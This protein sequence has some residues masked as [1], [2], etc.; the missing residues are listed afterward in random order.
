MI[1]ALALVTLL[2]IQKEAPQTSLMKRVVDFLSSDEMAGRNTPS[3]ELDQ[4]ADYIAK[5]F[6]EQNLKP[7]NG[8]SYFQ[9]TNWRTTETKVRNVIAILPGNDPVLKNEYVYLTAHYDHLG[10]RKVEDGKDGIYNGA[11]DNASGTA[12]VLGAAMTLAQEKPKRTIVFMTF[13][14]EEKGLVG[15]QFY[16]K[17]PIFPLKQTSAVINIEQIGRTDDTEGPRVNAISMT[18]FE[19]SDLG[20]VVNDA[21]AKSKVG[22]TGHPTNSF[23]YFGASDNFPFAVAGVPAHT[24][25]T[26]YEFPDYH[27][28]SDTPDKIDYKNMTSVVDVISRAVLSVA[29]RK[30]RIQW[31]PDEKRAARFIEAA[32]KLQSQ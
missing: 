9:I 23:A 32:K 10:A 7:G 3:P 21:G 28:V 11:N 25:C 12:G 29:N 15:S 1:S 8:D 30:D 5:T 27:K 26:A 22:T 16:V 2:G 19:L 6:K 20:K 14:G 4:C 31:N 18:G 17:N 13:Y 24:V